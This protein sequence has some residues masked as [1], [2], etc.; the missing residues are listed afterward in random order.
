MEGAIIGSEFG[1]ASAAD[2][3]GDSEW[4]SAVSVTV[5]ETEAVAVAVTVA[6]AEAVGPGLAGPA[7]GG[8]RDGSR[9]RATPD[10]CGTI[11]RSAATSCSPCFDHIECISSIEN[12]GV[13]R[14]TTE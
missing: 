1:S 14:C 8:V 2:G 9:A 6:G 3:F 13:L 10:A 5:A 7:P 11:Y 4:R 12:G